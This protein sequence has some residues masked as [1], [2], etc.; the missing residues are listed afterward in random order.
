MPQLPT[1]SS[2]PKRS[3]PTCPHPQASGEPP[4]QPLCHLSSLPGL[5]KACV[6]AAAELED[7]VLQTGLQA[8]GGG[9]TTAHTLTVAARPCSSL[10]PQLVGEVSNSAAPSDSFLS[11]KSPHILSDIQS[12]T[13][14]I[15]EPAAAF[16]HLFGLCQVECL[17]SHL[18][19]LIHSRQGCSLG[20]G[21]IP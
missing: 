8:V 7:T 4:P 20:K 21:G 10:L 13:M 15:R 3:E 19:F 14:P 9:A 5:A 16:L 18:H 2:P 17:P 12:L 6:G 1:V 11:G